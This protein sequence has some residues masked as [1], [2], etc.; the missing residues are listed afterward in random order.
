MAKKTDLEIFIAKAM[1]RKEESN[2]PFDLEIEGYG[3]VHFNKP[4]NNQLLNYMD[5]V[6]S[7]IVTEGTG[8]EA[9]VISQD[10]VQMVEASKELVYLCC[11]TLQQ[12]ELQTAL[13]IQDPM[14]TSI[15]V[16]GIEKTLDI[17]A[18]I[19]E[20]T[21]GYKLQEEVAEAIKN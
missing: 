2:K 19:S 16:F 6:S 8:E 15:E 5:K 17:A 21:K 1:K 20:K 10:L 14:E 12:T 3:L 7:A 13:E 4:S 11:P 9:K 18:Q